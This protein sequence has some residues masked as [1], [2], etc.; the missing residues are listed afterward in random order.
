[1]QWL[2]FNYTTY[3]N[4]TQLDQTMSP[5]MI[6]S[7]SHKLLMATHPCE[8]L[9]L[10]CNFGNSSLWRIQEISAFS[11]LL[12]NPQ[13][14]VRDAQDI[15]ILSNLSR[16]H[17]ISSCANIIFAFSK[18]SFAP[19]LFISLYLLCFSKSRDPISM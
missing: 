17:C 15:K 4:Q 11:G 19:I 8:L 6:C 5:I 18:Y 7:Q 14:M 9:E 3:Q 12:A 16:S 1:V 13:Y 10:T 2:R